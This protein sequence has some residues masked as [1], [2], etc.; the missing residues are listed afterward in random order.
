M[1]SQAQ[2]ICSSKSNVILYVQEND[3]EYHPLHQALSFFVQMM[4]VELIFKKY[5]I[6]TNIKI[7]YTNK[8]VPLK[9]IASHVK[10]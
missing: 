1:I 4:R 9:F 3:K 7:H 8:I 2:Y 5:A 10:I 6:K